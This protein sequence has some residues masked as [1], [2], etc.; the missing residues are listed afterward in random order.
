MDF[1]RTSTIDKEP[2][3]IVSAYTAWYL[4]RVRKNVS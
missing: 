3:V 1:Q 4:K 2:Y